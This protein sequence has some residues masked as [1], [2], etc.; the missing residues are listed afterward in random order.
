[1]KEMS[2][3]SSARAKPEILHEGVYHGYDFRIL[4]LGTHPC[5]YV[6]IPKEHKYFKKDYHKIGVL[7]HGGL[8][9]SENNLFGDKNREPKDTWWIGWDYA[10][11]GDFTAH[12]KMLY[13]CNAWNKR[14]T[15]REIYEEVK[16]VIDQLLV[17]E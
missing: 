15:T 10:H 7:C 17:K 14:W 9:F 5:A 6:R 2:Y 16:Y 1:M 13:V 8:T 3:T 11:Y 4:N 12:E